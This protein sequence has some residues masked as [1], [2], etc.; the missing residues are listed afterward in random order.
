MQGAWRNNDG[1][2]S[3]LGCDGMMS[4]ET[5]ENKITTEVNI[6]G[7]P[8]TVV[9]SS[10]LEYIKLIA[11]FVNERLS[12][13]N[14]TYPR[15]SRGKIIALGAMNLADDLIKSQRELEALRADNERMKQEREDMQYA[16]ERT[17]KLAQHYQNQYEELAL[18]MEEE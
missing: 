1:R 3:Y 13:L 16:L 4:N 12:G 15:M 17:H 10:S 5:N 2:N 11:R 9:A 7:E 8:L 14:Q 18:L 6:L